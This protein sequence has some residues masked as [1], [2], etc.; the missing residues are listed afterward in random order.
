MT[1]LGNFNLHD[2]L[3]KAEQTLIQEN[4][5]SIDETLFA[6]NRAIREGNA[7]AFNENANKLKHIAFS[8]YMA[9]E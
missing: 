7:P 3:S 4:F 9:T 5:L 2:G 6:I 1:K 8:I